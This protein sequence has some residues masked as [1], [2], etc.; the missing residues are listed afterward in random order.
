MRACCCA[1]AADGV[2]RSSHGTRRR[3][4]TALLRL[5]HNVMQGRSC[6]QTTSC[7]DTTRGIMCMQCS[8]CSIHIPT[9]SSLW[10][11]DI[12]LSTGHRLC[13][14]DCIHLCLASTLL[15]YHDSP[16]SV[17]RCEILSGIVKTNRGKDIR[18]RV[19]KQRDKGACS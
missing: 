7:Y 12:L 13:S 4:P 8:T 18:C 16:P 9:P 15:E 3:Q 10:A 1:K 14:Y 2:C 5:E 6:T 11:F 19:R 17:S